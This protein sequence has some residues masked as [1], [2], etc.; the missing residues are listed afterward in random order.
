MELKQLME[1]FGDVKVHFTSY[2]KYSFCFISA[3]GKLEIYAGGDKDD[4]YRFE[5]VA[6]KDYLISE[7]PISSAYLEGQSIYS[8]AW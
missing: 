8:E 1:Q 3:D 7:L 4:I 6:K 5:V 2:Y